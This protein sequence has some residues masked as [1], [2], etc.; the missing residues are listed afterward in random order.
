MSP[1]TWQPDVEPELLN[2]LEAARLAA[3]SDWESRW[4]A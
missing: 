4:S 2:D 3:A 1:D